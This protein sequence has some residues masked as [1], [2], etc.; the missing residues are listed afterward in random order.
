MIV[1]AQPLPITLVDCTILLHRIVPP[2]AVRPERSPE[3]AV[4]LAA[5]LNDE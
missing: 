5:S 3:A 4:R 1:V 2:E